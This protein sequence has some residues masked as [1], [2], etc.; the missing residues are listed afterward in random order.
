MRNGSRNTA[1]TSVYY[2][3]IAGYVTLKNTRDHLRLLNQLTDS[4]SEQ[5]RD[6]I[7]VSAESLAEMFYR[8][9]DELDTVLR[10]VSKD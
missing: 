3:P 6:D 2:L 8:V 5:E 10:S 1:T 4:R 7:A 9:A